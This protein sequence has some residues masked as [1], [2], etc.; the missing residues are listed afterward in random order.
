LGALGGFAAGLYT[1]ATN[2][3]RAKHYYEVFENKTHMVQ[4]LSTAAIFV[5]G[6]TYDLAVV[7]GHQ[8]L[9]LLKELVG[10]SRGWLWP[11]NLSSEFEKKNATYA[12]QSHAR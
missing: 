3:G 4:H 12:A 8:S 2:P 9:P 6:K 7:V 1:E 10:V 5:G 11:Q